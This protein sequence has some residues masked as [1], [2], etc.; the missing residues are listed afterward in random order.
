MNETTLRQF[1][2]LILESEN[3]TGDK[4]KNSNLI[5]EPDSN[6]KKK[7][8]EGS[9]AGHSL[10]GTNG[11]LTEP[12]GA[13]SFSDSEGSDTSVDTDA[14]QK[15]DSGD[16][17]AEA[18]TCEDNFKS[19]VRTKMKREASGTAAL[20]GVPVMPLG[21]GPSYP[22]AEPRSRSKA[23]RDITRVT[24]GAFGGALPVGKKK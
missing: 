12:D 18:E 23:L 9:T 17:C 14:D 22:G 1:V 21:A 24:G 6:K 15:I 5:L 8:R 7:K 4:K 16:S 20:G 11:L 13:E 10:N 2:R 3:E 19:P